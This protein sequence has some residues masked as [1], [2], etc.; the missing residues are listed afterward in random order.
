MIAKDWDVNTGGGGVAH[1]TPVLPAATVLSCAPLHVHPLTG[2]ILALWMRFL[3][4]CEL[5]SP[6]LPSAL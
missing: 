1:S 5:V 6:L 2:A 4:T 3:Q